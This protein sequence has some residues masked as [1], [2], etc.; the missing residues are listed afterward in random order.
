MYPFAAVSNA[1]T[2]NALSP[3]VYSEVDVWGFWNE[4]MPPDDDLPIPEPVSRRLQDMAGAPP[5]PPSSIDV[6]AFEW[7]S[8]LMSL[9]ALATVIALVTFAASSR[10]GIRHRVSFDAPVYRQDTP[11]PS[12]CVRGPC[13]N[14]EPS[15]AT[16]THPGPHNV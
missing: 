11:D 16:F 13:V 4:T 12:G 8:L 14:D 5:P 9:G 3:M 1:A 7:Y 10:I 2:T 6:P 15:A